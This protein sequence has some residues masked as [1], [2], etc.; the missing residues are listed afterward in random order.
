MAPFGAETNRTKQWRT[1]EP[2]R[3][4][5]HTP[6]C[7]FLHRQS[8]CCLVGCVARDGWTRLTLLCAAAAAAVAGNTPAGGGGSDRTT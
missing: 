3:Q 8:R 1:V 5:P 4:T 2:N 7:C 6:V